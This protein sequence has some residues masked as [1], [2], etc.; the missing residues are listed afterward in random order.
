MNRRRLG[1]QMQLDKQ[2]KDEELLR[3]QAEDI[4]RDKLEQQRLQEK[5][6]A[7]IQQ[8]R[9]EKRR[10][11]EQSTTPPA[12]TTTTEPT[13]VEREI[14]KTNYTRSRL[15]FR[16]TDGSFFTEDFS[17]DD[18]MSNVYAYLQETL[19]SNQY[20]TGSYTLRTT[21]TRVTLTRDN[22][23]TL[24]ELELC[25]TAVLLVLNRNGNINTPA[26]N[27]NQNNILQSIPFFF[28]WFMLQLNFIYKFIIEKLFG[29]RPTTNEQ[30]RVNN[31]TNQR[32][33]TPTRD[34]F[35]TDTTEKSTIR[36]FRN[37]QDDS[38]DE[39]KRTWNGN[40]TQQL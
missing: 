4:R 36:R 20:K 18:R 27:T 19:P 35:R 10:K 21:H 14:P 1:Q 3:K 38:D 15:Q 34:N 29:T 8:D 26:N 5:L 25:P 22:P 7:Q 32:Q 6:K 2:K 33:T 13:K 9:D 30:T 12:T 31:P 24:K 37:T 39:E 17:C 23:N 28:T 11:Y 16:L 40:S